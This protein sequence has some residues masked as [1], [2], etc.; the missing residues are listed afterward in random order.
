MPA[1]QTPF[2]VL[3]HTAVL[4][5]FVAVTAVDVS[6]GQR[7]GNYLIITAP[8]F[9]NSVPLNEFIAFKQGQGFAVSTYGPPSGTSRAAI[10]S[11][12]DSLWGTPQ[13]PQ[14]LLIV[15]DTDRRVGLGRG[16]DSTLDR[17]SQPAGGDGLAVR[18]HG[19]GR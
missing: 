7:D 3:L 19:C 14:Y 2:R 10:K 16:C 8:D 17:S 18:V 1:P 15:G 4:L 11:Y 6:A 9:N 13:A 5:A 12:I